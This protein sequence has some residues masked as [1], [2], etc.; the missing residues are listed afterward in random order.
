MGETRAACWRCSLPCLFYPSICN[1]PFTVTGQGTLTYGRQSIHGPSW[2]HLNCAVANKL[3]KNHLVPLTPDL[4]RLTALAAN[5]LRARYPSNKKADLKQDPKT[6]NHA[7]HR[8]LVSTGSTSIPLVV[9]ARGPKERAVS[10]CSPP[11]TTSQRPPRIQQPNSHETLHTVPLAP[12]RFTEPES[13]ASSL[14]N[15]TA[16]QSVLV[17]FTGRIA[18]LV[19]ADKG[20]NRTTALAFKL[21]R[22]RAFAITLSAILSRNQ[23]SFCPVHSDQS[24]KTCV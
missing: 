5:Y 14:S 11:T 7:F 10:V 1:D 22:P 9:H 19:D 18:C 8:L 21:Q 2:L 20:F 24:F 6:Q 23:I 4:C 15:P 17:V 12:R 16:W 3:H 13:S